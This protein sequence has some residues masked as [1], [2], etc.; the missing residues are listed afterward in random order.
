MIVLIVQRGVF[1]NL[2][3]KI[4]KQMSGRYSFHT[5]I[6]LCSIPVSL[7]VFGLTFLHGGDSS[8][9]CRAIEALA[10]GCLILLIFPTSCGNLKLSLIFCL[11]SAAVLFALAFLSV[12]LGIF[13]LCLA[14][15]LL[16]YFVAAGTIC[17][18]NITDRIKLNVAWKSVELFSKMFYA[19]V[20]CAAGIVSVLVGERFAWVA[21]AV[22]ALLFGLL[23]VR[24]Y[25]AI[26]LFVPAKKERAIKMMV[27]G[28]LRGVPEPYRNTDSRMA[29]VY[30]KAVDV[31]QRKQLFLQPG[32]AIEDLAKE[33]LTNKSY[34]SRA[35]NTYAGTG[36][37]NFVNAFRI[38]YALELMEKDRKLKVNELA[39]MCGFSTTVTF[40]SAF[41]ENRGTT[42]HEYMTNLDYSLPNLS[43][44]K[45]EAR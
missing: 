17:A 25:F 33:V 4:V 42:P 39:T 37:C 19:L 41:K 7:I 32:L 20:F 5:L 2:V 3:Q 27:R 8:F 9:S 1:H 16:I 44:K 24:D 34:L 13:M 23:Y 12:K 31:M 14:F 40:N 36:F 35:I 28:D 45:A 26:S 21:L 22:Y 11:F 38:R 29:K 10:S 6:R 30:L 18:E 15:L 43:R